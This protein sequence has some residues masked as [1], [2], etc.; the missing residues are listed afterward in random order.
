[1][2]SILVNQY[3]VSSD[4]VYVVYVICVPC[5]MMTEA[6]RQFAR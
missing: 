3:G 6:V 5:S 4:V 2:R 1:M